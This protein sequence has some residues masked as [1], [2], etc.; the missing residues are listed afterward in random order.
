MMSTMMTTTMMITMLTTTSYGL[1]M[2]ITT[3]PMM[4]AS[5]GNGNEPLQRQRRSRVM[6][7]TRANELSKSMK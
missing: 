7:P 5:T 1:R 6:L 3:M 4:M 2:M